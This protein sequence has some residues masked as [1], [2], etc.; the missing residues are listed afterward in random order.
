MSA[1][2][3]HQTFISSYFTLHG[4]EV[5]SMQSAALRNKIYPLD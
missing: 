3:D 2:A 4:F 1:L 5:M